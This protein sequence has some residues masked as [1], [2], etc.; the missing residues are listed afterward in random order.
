MAVDSF[1]HSEPDELLNKAAAQ[2]RKQLETGQDCHA[3]TVLSAFP[4]L[5]SDPERAL[6]LVVLEFYFRRQLG[7]N[8]DPRQWYE[9]FPQWSEQLRARLEAPQPAELNHSQQETAALG[10]SPYVD[11]NQSTFVDIPV[12]DVPLLGR[13][14]IVEEIGRGGMGVVYRARDLVLERQVALKVIRSGSLASAEE[15]RCFYREAR[16]AAGLRHPNIVPIYG[17]GLHEGQHCFSMALFPLGSLN[18]H[19]NRYQHDIR[20]AVVLVSKAARAVHAAHERGIIHRDLKPGNILLDEHGDPVVSDFGL[21]KRLD[22]SATQT[23]GDRPMGTP[24]YMAPEQARCQT[25]T[26][27]SDIWSLGVILYE[28]LTG[29]RPFTGESLDVVKERV[30]QAEPL[31]PRRLRRDV[32]RDLETIALKC[33]NKEPARRY[34]SAAELADELERWLSGEAIRTRPESRWQRLGRRIRAKRV[35]ASSLPTWVLIVLLILSMGAAGT[36][37]IFTYFSPEARK[38][39]RQ[40]QALASIQHE[41]AEGRSVTLVGPLGPPKWYRWRTERDRPPL[42]ELRKWPLKLPSI[43]GISLLDL[44]LDPQ[45]NSYRFFA[46]VAPAN[47]SRMEMG[48]YF[49]CEELATATGPEHCF[50]LFR[51]TSNLYQVT[52]AQLA[53]AAYHEG[54]VN[55]ESEWHEF[56]IPFKT[57]MGSAPLVPPPLIVDDKKIPWRRIE[58]HVTPDAVRAFCNGCQMGGFSLPGQWRKLNLWWRTTHKAPF[59][60]PTF[61]PRGSLGLYVREGPAYFRNVTVEPLPQP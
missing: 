22:V 11:A 14:E 7:Q 60:L 51:L 30:L 4:S 34:V 25:S 59:Q 61:H 33:L 16:S 26:T 6:A 32:P 10:T 39:Q 29:C 53:I 20:A 28:L 24:A 19:L 47:N 36:W 17:M 58:V 5:A 8:P 27:A 48:L 13:H 52:S 2:L 31:S 56:L 18:Q 50:G 41:G 12:D 45:Q 55:E 42:P 21:A 44:M 35:V 46:E 3:E 9:R 37:A 38:R 54:D 15:V 43:E 57:Q 49:V 23:L 1:L 40:E